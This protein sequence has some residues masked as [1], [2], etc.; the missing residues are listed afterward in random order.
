M[1]GRLL[2]RWTA[3]RRSSF[4]LGMTHATQR[5]ALAVLGRRTL[6]APDSLPNPALPTGTDTMP[7][8]ENVVVLMLENHSYDNILG[9]LGRGP[10]QSP[11]GDGF[12]LA[13]DGL[14]T[15]TNPYPDGRLQRAFRMPTTCQLSARPSQEWAASHNQFNRGAND[16]FVRTTI[17]PFTSEI[18]GAVA[19]GYWTGGDLPL[20]YALANTF[21]IADRW[22][23]SCLGQTDPQRRFLIAA[24]AQGMTDDIGTGPGNAAANSTLG[25]PAANGTIFSRLTQAGISW[26]DYNTAYPTG[27]T[28]ELYPTNDGPYGQTNAPPISQFFSDAKAGKLPQFSLLDPDYGSQ[29]QENPQNMA[30]GE[31][32]LG[33]VIDALRSS[34]QWPKT[35]FILTYDEHGGYYDHVPPP[36]AIAPDSIQPLVNPGESTYDGYARYGFR[37]PAIVIGPYVKPNYV[38]SVVYDHTSI[39]AFLERKWNLGAMTYRDANANDLTEFLDLQAMQAGQPT[40]PELPALVAAGNTPAR[41]ACSKAGPGTIPPTGTV[42]HPRV[43]RLEFRSVKVSRRLRGIVVELRTNFGAMR[44]VEVELRHGH[45]RLVRRHVG[46]VGTRGHRVILRVRGGVP[47]AGHYVVGARRG[48]RLLGERTVVIHAARKLARL[49]G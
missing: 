43:Q 45:R 10:G 15:A 36:V 1:A 8:I 18:V 14:P 42:H 19:M 4:R 29:S 38:S 11:R 32:F 49:V 6:R 30:V 46:R 48:G 41:L 22:F 35:L 7:Q 39:L 2:P 9:M 44:G 17:D 23:S 26:A 20:T 33:R 24:T 31:G 40:F 27:T 5:E 25:V 21:P 28:M 37:V 16:G 3:P 12:T 34:P 47:A 13:P